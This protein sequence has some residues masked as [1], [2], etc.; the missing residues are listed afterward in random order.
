MIFRASL[1]LKAL[2]SILE[3]AAGTALLLVSHAL[4]LRL[5]QVLTASELLEDPHDV[6]AGTI[7]NVAASLAPASQSFAAFYLISHGTLKLMMVMGVLLNRAWAYPAFMAVLAGF[8]VYQ[9]YRLSLGMNWFLIAMTVLDVLVLL[10]T[11]HEYRIVRARGRP[12]E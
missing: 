12:A 11:I 9:V 8:I 1:W 6:V 7:R 2:N 10:L 4:I 5:A 3:I